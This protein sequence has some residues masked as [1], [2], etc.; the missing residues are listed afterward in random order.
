MVVGLSELPC[1][2]AHESFARDNDFPCDQLSEANRVVIPV[3]SLQGEVDNDSFDQF[4]FNASGVHAAERVVVVREQQRAMR[5]ESPAIG[6]CGVKSS[7]SAS[8]WWYTT[9]KESFAG[10]SCL[11]T[12]H[13]R[14]GHVGGLLTDP[15]TL[16]WA[17]HRGATSRDG[18]RRSC[19]VR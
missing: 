18:N 3:R 16:K 19:P 11:C 14:L 10:S 13:Q 2:A 7:L 9:R 1:T 8:S 15:R 6:L 5:C 12:L 4:Y 17:E